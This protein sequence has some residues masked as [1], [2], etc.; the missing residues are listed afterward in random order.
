MKWTDDEDRILTVSVAGYG[1]GSWKIVASA[2][3]GRTGKQCRER[4]T[5]QIDPSLNRDSWTPEEDAVLIRQQ[6]VCGNQWS[7]IA[8]YFRG[9]TCSGVK[10]RWLHLKRRRTVITP[11]QLR[12]PPVAPAAIPSEP[13]QRN[14]AV[15]E[16]NGPTV[17]VEEFE[18]GAAEDLWSMTF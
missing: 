12:D 5:H 7:R 3:P 6:Q 17:M 11:E 13:E 2:L 1:T 15:A 18:A 14:Q 4:W 9:R 16:P 10:N 8:K